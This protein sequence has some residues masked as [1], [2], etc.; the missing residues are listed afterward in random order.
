MKVLLQRFD[1]ASVSCAGRSQG[2]LN[3][4]F[5]DG[6]GGGALLDCYDEWPF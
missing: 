6:L 2:R 5:L 4:Y 1:Y 3:V